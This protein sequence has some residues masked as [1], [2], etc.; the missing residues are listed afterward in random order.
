MEVKKGDAVIVNIAPFI[1]SAARCSESI[2][3]VVL[4][5]DGFQ[6]LVRTEPPC[7]EVSLWVMLSWLEGRPGDEQS[8]VSSAEA[9]G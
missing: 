6:A 5:V 2:S 4:D 3:C 7:R 9:A 8:L 1:G